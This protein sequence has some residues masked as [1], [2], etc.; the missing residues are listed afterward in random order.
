MLSFVAS[1]PAEQDKNRIALLVAG[2]LFLLLSLVYYAP[3]LG[4]LPQ[5]IHE[6]AQSDRLSLA[7]SFYN[8]GLNFFRPQTLN[9]TSIDGVAGVEFPI[10]PYLAALGAKVFGKSSLIVIYR[11][12]NVS[13][14]W[15]SY[16]FLFRLVFERTRHFVAALLPGVFLATSPVFAYYAGNFLPDPVG[17]A[18]TLVASYYLLRFAQHQQFRDLLR[19]IC[20][21]TLA[22]LIKTSAA[23]YLMAAMGSVVLWTYLY[24]TVLT[25]RQKLW[26]MV[27]CAGSLLLVVGYA[28][29]NRHLNEVYSSTSFLAQPMPIESTEQYEMVITRINDL[30]LY[31]YFTKP[32][33]FIFKCCG[34][35]CLLSLLRIVRTEWLWAGQIILAAIGSWVFFKL[36]GRQLADHDYYVLA[37]CWPGIILL[38]AL[39]AVQATSWQLPRMQWNY[40]LRFIN[41]A[42]FG[43]A[44]IGLIWVA[45]PQYR[46][47]MSDDYP[48]FSDYYTYRWMR[49]GAAAMQ[50]AKVPATATLLVLGED[51]PNLSLVYFDRC[52]LVWKPDISRMPSTELLDKMTNAGLDHLLMRQEVFQGLAQAHPDLLPAFTELISNG[53]YVLLK[54]KAVSKHW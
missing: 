37:P 31:E 39:A 8:N 44:L 30:W 38:V 51:A 45:L 43:A 25:L 12:L 50:A 20:F 28:L 32:H 46:A 54:R 18:I 5:G 34:V 16:W 40:G 53:Q 47:R 3:S 19:A 6:W 7:I 23:I 13:T 26:F 41:Y 10:V 24:A 29:Y 48:P 11:G 15:L 22:T 42:A 14:A 1:P 2:L 17:V 36:M 21:F 52:G 4:W 33:Y 35:V 9:L 49:G 27:L